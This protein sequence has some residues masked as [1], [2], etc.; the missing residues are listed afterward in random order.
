MKKITIILLAFIL[1]GCGSKKKT[2]NREKEET[3]ISKVVERVGTVFEEK[4]VD[5]TVVKEEN[6]LVISEEKNIEFIADSSGVVT[7]E[8][9]KT[10]KGY[11]KTIKGIK[12]AKISDRTTE[13]EKVSKDSLN[14]VKTNSKDSVNIEKENT[15]SKTDKDTRTM[16]LDVRRGFH[17]WI[18]IVVVTVFLVWKFRNKIRLF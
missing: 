10:D 8:F 12:E 3:E 2:V 11:K 16:N 4:K 7:I 17:W 13:T 15:A 5:S 14:V 1:A 6:I 9:E 18:L